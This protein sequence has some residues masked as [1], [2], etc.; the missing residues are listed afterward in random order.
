MSGFPD[1]PSD[2]H[3]VVTAD[4]FL[5]RWNE[6][7]NKDLPEFAVPTEVHMDSEFAALFWKVAYADGYE[8]GAKDTTAAVTAKHT[9]MSSELAVLRD[10]QSDRATLLEKVAKAEEEL[11]KAAEGLKAQRDQIIDMERARR[12]MLDEMDQL[13][14]A[15]SMMKSRS[16]IY[17]GTLAAENLAQRIRRR[18]FGGR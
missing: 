18:M 11:R 7:A 13:S 1:I 4:Q 17:L 3:G 2:F 5:R 6:L 9:E 10:N 15:N 8:W 16:P 12:A 14:A